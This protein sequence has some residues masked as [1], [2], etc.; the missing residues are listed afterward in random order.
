MILI[1]SDQVWDQIPRSLRKQSYNHLKQNCIRSGLIPENLESLGGFFIPENMET[2]VVCSS[3]T[4]WK[5]IVVLENIEILFGGMS[6]DGSAG[7]VMMGRRAAKIAKVKGREDAKRGKAFAR[8]GKKIIMVRDWTRP[9]QN[10]GRGARGGG[11]ICCLPWSFG[12]LLRI[13]F[14]TG[15]GGC[16]R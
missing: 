5:L 7:V 1:K 11:G 16:T 4:E 2:T 8:I 10:R 9:D 13:P 3:L 14:G 15:G 12:H 6:G